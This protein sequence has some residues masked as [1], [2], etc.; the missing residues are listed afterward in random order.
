MNE[1]EFRYHN[2][3]DL[4]NLISSKHPNISPMVDVYEDSKKFYI[5]TP[6]Y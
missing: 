6:H 2:M 5:V 4:Y 1:K 3:I